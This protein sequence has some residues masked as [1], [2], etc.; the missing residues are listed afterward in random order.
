M[1]LRLSGI[2]PAELVSLYQDGALSEREYQAAVEWATQPPARDRWSAYLR[3]WFLVF[4]LLLLVCGI[5]MFGAYNWQGLPRFHKLAIMQLLVLGAW[6]RSR[7]RGLDSKEGTATLW[8][9]SLLVG[10]LLAVYGQIY[11]TGADAYSL[12]L[13]WSLLIGPWCLAARSNLIWLTEAV[14]ANIT[15]CLFW[16]QTVG[17]DFA[18]FAVVYLAF[19]LVLAGL[20]EAARKTNPWMSV[21]LTDALLAA[22]LAPITVAACLAPW[23][24]VYWPCLGVT[25][26]AL[27][28]LYAR[29]RHE[30][31]KMTLVALSLASLGGSLMIFL[32]IESAGGFL[33][34]SL[35]L[36]AE[37][38]MAARW[39][40]RVHQSSSLS[41]QP[42]A[43]GPQAG[44]QP[45]PSVLEQL[46]RQGLLEENPPLEQR[47]SSVAA[48]AYLGCLTALGTWFASWFFLLFV[49]TIVLDSEATA[50]AMGLLLF[51]A[52]LAARRRVSEAS[53]FLIYLLL[54]VNLAG[55]ILV[56]VGAAG[57]LSAD[58]ST[59]ALIFLLLHVTGLLWYEDHLGRCLFAFGSVLSGG[60]LSAES[61][62]AAPLSL[63]LLVVAVLVS[64]L[65][66]RQRGWLLS[67]WR[68]WHG[69]VAFG[70]CC[71]LLFMVGV[72][73]F[74][75]P[76]LW[77]PDRAQPWL[78]AAGLTLVAAA[79]AVRLQAPASA[80]VA[81]LVLGG[82]TFTMPGLMAATLVFILAFHTRSQATSTVAI[83]ALL[84][85][86]IHYYYNLELDF[87]A[88]SASL[89]GGGLLLLM[90]RSSLRSQE[91][92]HAF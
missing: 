33:L 3:D 32:F 42:A 18:A 70:W 10:A 22:G 6:V 81:L 7:L 89:I 36:L 52:T 40:K 80:V 85:F 25:L 67:R 88:K 39:L 50:L 83:L 59:L 87:M 71:G 43:E 17:A 53:D 24:S 64:S 78:A 44:R 26:V 29:F 20:W 1:D 54:S 27:G 57:S 5:I 19:N 75:V 72:W 60:Y 63:C 30:I 66:C 51:V 15:F 76:F 79:T 46:A 74:D 68:K 41:P 55:Q 8:A 13:G 56:A 92:T 49:F 77:S 69:P 65:Y 31:G 21:G 35:G 38:T 91:T 28:F 58:V 86:G 47:S 90:A 82:L 61:G 16:T 9:A 12:F 34:V 37:L 4:G 11:Q 62:G 84:L 45:R 23:E 73:G 14:L 2:P 48:P